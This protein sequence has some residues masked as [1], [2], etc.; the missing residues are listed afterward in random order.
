MSPS[1]DAEANPPFQTSFQGMLDGIRSAFNKSDC[2]VDV[3]EVW[4]VIESYKSS[5]I[6]WN[7]FAFY[8][9]HKYKRNLVD[10]HEKYNVMILCWGPNTRSCIHDHSGSHCFMKVGHRLFSQQ[11]KAPDSYS[12]V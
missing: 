2:K 4:Q 12:N 8:D 1:I 6:D 11:E 3:D 5:P 7:R 10:E 9:P